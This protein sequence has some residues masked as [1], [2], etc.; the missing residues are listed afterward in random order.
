ME[1]QKQKEM[2]HEMETGDYMGGLQG[3]GFSEF[4][5]PFWCSYEKA[6]CRYNWCNKGGLSWGSSYFVETT[7]LRNTS[8]RLPVMALIKENEFCLLPSKVKHL[9]TLNRRMPVCYVLSC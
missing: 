5:L 4:G 2:E 9:A 1:N 6:L 8:L 3:L 7:K